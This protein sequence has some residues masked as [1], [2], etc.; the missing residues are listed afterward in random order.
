MKSLQPE[1]LHIM[2]STSLQVICYCYCCEYVLI[3]EGREGYWSAHSL[4]LQFCSFSHKLCHV[5]LP[6]PRS[7]KLYYYSK[8]GTSR[9]F[10]E[11]QHSTAGWGLVTQNLLEIYYKGDPI[12]KLGPLHCNC[13]SFHLS[14][15]TPLQ[16]M[17][18]FFAKKSD[19]FPPNCHTFTK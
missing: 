17:S 9:G 1:S 5:T 11:S 4:S 13:I 16:V 6:G 10:I 18:S 2:Q 8:D 7:A 19:T 3:L 14:L 15:Q 12:F